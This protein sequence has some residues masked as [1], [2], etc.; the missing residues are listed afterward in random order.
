M[1]KIITAVTI[2]LVFGSGFVLANAYA[3]NEIAGSPSRA[4]ETKGLINTNV[5]N[6]VT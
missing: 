6:K 1:N 2:I 5:L 4:Y 3:K